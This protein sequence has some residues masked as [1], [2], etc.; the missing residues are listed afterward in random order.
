MSV[1]QHPHS[2][3]FSREEW[4]NVT[5]AAAQNETAPGL[6][7]REAT[8]RAVAEA[9]GFSDAQPTPEPIELLRQP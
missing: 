5:H 9:S 3:R 2:I 4:E 7:I 1:R 8:V 6:L